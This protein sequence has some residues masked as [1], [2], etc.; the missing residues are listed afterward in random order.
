M[1]THKC[2]FTERDLDRWVRAILEAWTAEPAS[3]PATGEAWAADRG[4]ANSVPGLHLRLRLRKDSGS[5]TTVE[6]N[7][8]FYLMKKVRGRKVSRHLGDRQIMSVEQARA[9]TRELLRSLNAGI[10]PREERRREEEA[11]GLR[12]LSYRDALEQFLAD[13]DVTEGTRR[14]YRQSVNTTFKAVADKPLTHLTS[15]R[16]RAIH[17][18]R[19]NTSKSRADQDMRVLRLVWNYCRGRLKTE[20]GAAVLGP[21]PVDVLNKRSRGPG[22]R[23]W[24]NVPRRKTTIPKARL[25]D[26]FQALYS[27][28]DDPASSPTRRV[29]CLLLEALALTGC[30]F[31]ELATLPWGQV[32]TDM[33]VFT[34]PDTSSKNRRALVRPITRRV[35][36]ILEQLAGEGYVFPGRGPRQTQDTLREQPLNN[37]RKVQMEIQARTGL[38]ITPH[39][40]R[41]V[42]A[43]A[44]TR[45]DLPGEAI[46]RLLNHMGHEE[47]TSGYI[48]FGLDEL[49]EYSQKVEDKIL[50]D[51]G[52]AGTDKVEDM[53]AGLEPE[54]RQQLLDA[55][56]RE[57]G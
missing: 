8:D 14:K 56:L 57:A 53:L 4:G 26:W 15:E 31:N 5:W 28:R 17:R 43:S 37:T 20:D 29:S 13:A 51:A 32:D 18:E 21:N 35:Q 42:W 52:L 27:I 3:I 54:Q 24:N 23:G 12:A 11:R 49:R 25:P 34:I 55:L 6:P 44:A 41:R 9:G 19:S 38:W 7:A 45:A 40:L 39:D 48:E 16:V 33:A 1:A 22:Q 50:A 47:V 10:D 36:Q 2:N 30:R 46:K